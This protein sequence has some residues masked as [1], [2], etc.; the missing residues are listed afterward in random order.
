VASVSAKMYHSTALKKYS[1]FDG[2][3]AYYIQRQVNNSDLFLQMGNRSREL[4]CTLN[5]KTQHRI[6]KSDKGLR[7]CVPVQGFAIT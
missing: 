7:F 6:W 2:Q 3:K 1:A 5:L 4:G